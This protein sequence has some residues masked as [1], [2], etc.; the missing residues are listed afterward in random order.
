MHC[1]LPSFL[2]ILEPFSEKHDVMGPKC[3]NLILAICTLG[4]NFGLLYSMIHLFNPAS[5]SKE[6]NTVTI[7]R[8]DRKTELESNEDVERGNNKH[9]TLIHIKIK[10]CDDNPGLLS[11]HPPLVVIKGPRLISSLYQTP[12]YPPERG[13]KRNTVC[14]KLQLPSIIALALFVIAPIRFR[15]TIPVIQRKEAG[16]PQTGKGV[17]VA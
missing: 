8:Q 10:T 13:W 1:E 15:T 9:I 17:L 5:S 3:D 2:F 11:K 12:F 16:P 4:E 14:L 7:K 6:P